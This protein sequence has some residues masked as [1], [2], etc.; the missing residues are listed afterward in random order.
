MKRPAP[1][2]FGFV[3]VVTVVAASSV[4]LDANARAR[5]AGAS[6]RGAFGQSDPRRR[7]VRGGRRRLLPRHGPGPERSGRALRQRRSRA[8]HVAG[9][10]RRQRQAVGRPRRHQL[11]RPRLP[12]GRCR[13]IRRSDTAAPARPSGSPTRAARTGGSISASST[14]RASRK[15]PGRILQRWNL[16]LD[17][18]QPGC[19]P[20][21]F[22]N[23]AK[24]PG[25]QDR[26]ARHD[27]QRHAV[28]H[29]LVLRLRHRHRRLSAVPEPGLRRA[30]G[31]ALGCAAVLH[32]PA[33]YSD[34][35][36]VKPYRVGDVVRAAA[37]SAPTRSSRRPI[38][39]TRLGEP[40]LQRRR[41]VLLGRSHL[42]SRKPISRTSR[43]SCS[44][45]R[46]PARSTPRSSRPT[47]ST[48]RGR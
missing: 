8:Q 2:L 45:R 48:T 25:V 31:G 42:L 32:R 43:S 15:R 10:D 35:T 44:T 29:R 5:A 46:G 3:A 30:R 41:A 39:T 18:R 26:L 20:D 17:K 4:R 6:R 21:P 7:V 23:A 34:K 38:R 24:Y 19:P 47:T 28:R 33:Y 22:E 12:E 40:E 27:A 11:R 16:W 1:A 9:V 36:L 13:R 37:T 14:N